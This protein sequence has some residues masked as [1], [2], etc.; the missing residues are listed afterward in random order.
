V[1]IG[2]DTDTVAAIAGALLGARWGASAVPLRWRAK[3]HGW[4]SWT[5]E[6]VVRHAIL[7]GQGGKPDPHGWPSVESMLPHYA[8]HWPAKPVLVP[9]PDD[10]GMLVGNAPGL[11]D[12]RDVDE[13]VSLCRMRPSDAPAGS[14]M[15]QL[16]L[17]DEPGANPNLHLQLR[18][19]AE[20]VAGWR[21]DRRTVVIH[22]VRGISR[23]LVDAPELE[24]GL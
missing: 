22:C 1:R 7:A 8:S 2:N 17:I 13:V 6:D 5:A 4:P 9:L 15:H 18:D 14:R 19:V 3:L 10:P 12:A 20:T 11:A 24:L 21:D 23:T 16:H